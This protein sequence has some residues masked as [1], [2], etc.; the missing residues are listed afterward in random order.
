MADSP[1]TIPISSSAVTWT[2]FPQKHHYFNK[3]K[4]SIPLAPAKIAS[5]FQ[6]NGGEIFQ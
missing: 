2:A 1:S 5:I 4:L 3:N 6:F